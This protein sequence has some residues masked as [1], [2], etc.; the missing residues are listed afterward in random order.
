MKW[1]DSRQPVNSP[2]GQI[3]PWQQ[4][5]ETDLNKVLKYVNNSANKVELFSVGSEVSESSK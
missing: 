5:V 1:L 2:K 3:C 4:L